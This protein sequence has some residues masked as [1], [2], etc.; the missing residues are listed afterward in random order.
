M[1][2]GSKALYILP[3]RSLMREARRIPVSTNLRRL[4]ALPL[5]ATLIRLEFELLD[6]Y[7]M[8][9]RSEQRSLVGQEVLGSSSSSVT[10]EAL[11]SSLAASLPIKPPRI[12]DGF[13]LVSGWKTEFPLV[14]LFDGTLRLNERLGCHD[15]FMSGH[16]SRLE[17]EI[18]K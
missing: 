1:S 18:K 8:M 2:L 16:A 12:L 11:E 10:A 5:L 14:N 15:P 6:R 7:G 13:S 3:I 17:G 9:P 4:T